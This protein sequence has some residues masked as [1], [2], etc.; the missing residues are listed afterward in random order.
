MR[1]R[2]EEK[3]NSATRGRVS[4]RWVAVQLAFTGH[5]HQ[6]SFGGV[7][8]NHPLARFLLQYGV[9]TQQPVQQQHG[10]VGELARTDGM[11]P[12]AEILRPGHSPPR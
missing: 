9:V 11:V 10:Q 4:I 3:G 5:H 6:G 1:L 2:S 12:G 8:Q 7:A